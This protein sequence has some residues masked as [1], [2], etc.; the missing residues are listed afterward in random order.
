[1]LVAV[2]TD[3][4]E[5]ITERV[6]VPIAASAAAPAGDDIVVTALLGYGPKNGYKPKFGPI[7]IWGLGRRYE[8]GSLT[9]A[10]PA[11]FAAEQDGSGV[12]A[13]GAKHLAVDFSG[14]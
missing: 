1:V 11:D 12:I 2:D 3:L 6:I 7:V 10:K 5:A 4:R 9:S 14:A 8:F 13:A